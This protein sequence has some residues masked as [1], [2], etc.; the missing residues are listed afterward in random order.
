M[1]TL[2]INCYFRYRR[3]RRLIEDLSIDGSNRLI[4]ETGWESVDWIHLAQKRD[5]WQALVKAVM[6]L[7]GVSLLAIK[8]LAIK[9]YPLLN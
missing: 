4:L 2:L 7:R 1:H 6:K 3:R 9:T 8:H 5:K